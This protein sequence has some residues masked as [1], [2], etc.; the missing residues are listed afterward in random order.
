M[1]DLTSG[2]QLGWWWGQLHMEAGI[3]LSKTRLLFEVRMPKTKVARSDPPWQP[4]DSTVTFDGVLYNITDDRI[5]W[6][7]DPHDPSSAYPVGIHWAASSI[8]ID[9]DASHSGNCA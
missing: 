4:G 7:I 6:K 5:V 8:P 1:S 3:V 9:T 2:Q